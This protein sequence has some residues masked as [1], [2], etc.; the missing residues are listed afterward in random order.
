VFLFRTFLTSVIL[1]VLDA[2]LASAQT[3]PF[4]FNLF[5][6]S[7]G[8]V[9]KI[10]NG[11]SISINADVG[12]KG[13]LTITA[14]Y[15]GTT[16]AT[17]STQP[18]SWLLGSTQ[19]A[20]TVPASETFPLVLTPSQSLTLTVTFAPTN[21]GGANANLTIPYA[22]PLSGGTLNSDIVLPFVGTSPNYTLTY[23][24][25]P[26]NNFVALASGGTIQFNPT[27]INTT[28]QATLA[29]LNS[30]TGTGGITGISIAQSSVFQ[31]TGVPLA[32]PTVPYSLDP[33][34][35]LS[36][37]VQYTPTVVQNTP[38][39]GVITINFIDGTSDTVNLSGN[40]ASSTYKYTYLSN[41]MP[42]N[43]SPNNTI[44]LPSV[45]VAASGT[46]PNT[47][48]V[49]LTVTNSGNANGTINSINAV[50]NP[51]FSLVGVP[52]TPPILKPGDKE[53]FTI[54]Y[55]P[56][57]V[58]T[59]TGQL[60]VGG[61]VFILSA[62]GLGPQLS[63]SYI[64]PAGTIINIGTPAAVDFPPITISQ[65]E[66]INFTITNSGTTT[67]T[68]SLINTTA[69]F[70]LTPPPTL[71]LTLDP[72]K[73]SQF[74]IT[75]TPTTGST[76]TQVL[77][78][79]NTQVQLI[80]SGSTPPT[81]PSYTIS[82]PSGTV[83]PVTQAGVSLT[84]AKSYPVE[85]TGVLTLTTSGKFGTDPAAQFST[86][87]SAGNRTVDFTI[88]ANSTSADFVGQGPQ[89]LLQT[90]TVAETITLTPS[91]MTTGGVDITP[92]SPTTLQFTIP[93][94]APALTNVQP[95][96]ESSS[97]FTLL[98]TGYSP[99]RDLKSLSVTFIPAS[100]FSLATSQFPFDLSQSAGLWFASTSSQSFGGQFEISIPF[101]L[102]GSAPSGKTL[103][104]TIA[105]VSATVSNS[106]GTSSS[107]Q[108]TL[109]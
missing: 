80:G 4:D 103:L 69:P 2:A 31:L 59:Q 45:T 35:S 58:G 44:T 43:V 29:I 84:L 91:F 72:G 18:Q 60:V 61:D 20:V 109:P 107:L 54:T 104:Q 22:E 100:G 40:G 67:A 99:T 27:Q 94:S 52:A 51:P 83:S 68:V 70:S 108:A 30:G 62:Q 56:T 32:S 98:V 74:G 66:K 37:G 105:S 3:A 21:A 82:G 13:S 15:T 81:L 92:A 101:N 14:T 38:D 78:I 96:S 93:S 34:K 95:S 79:D 90:G 53:S 10:P 88:P 102:S 5:V 57:K 77:Q 39:T 19:F 86:G 41:G 50:P 55:T 16:Q 6:T 11:Q 65:S 7:N 49:I 28:A 106:V 12:T 47:S 17:I 76:V 33:G 48:S 23:A 36:I 8:N 24:L 64:T 71:P 46:T 97:G 26:A 63:F 9:V 87:S 89:I 42:V 25:A 1:A 85:L 73:S 75:F